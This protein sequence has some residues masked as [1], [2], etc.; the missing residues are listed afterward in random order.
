MNAI[1]DNFIFVSAI[2]EFVF[3]KANFNFKLRNIITKTLP[4]HNPILFVKSFRKFEAHVQVVQNHM[5]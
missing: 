5:K 1:C 4:I 3:I 2:G